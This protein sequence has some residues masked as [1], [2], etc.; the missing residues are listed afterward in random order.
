MSRGMA[1]YE[2][3]QEMHPTAPTPAVMESE[4]K[5]CEIEAAEGILEACIDEVFVRPDVN[6]TTFV[7][8]I[9]ST[10]TDTDAEDEWEKE[11]SSWRCLPQHWQEILNSRLAKHHSAIQDAKAFY[12]HR[13]EEFGAEDV[14]TKNAQKKMTDLQSGKNSC[15]IVLIMKGTGKEGGQDLYKRCVQNLKGE[16]KVS[17]SSKVL[18]HKVC[19]ETLKL[20]TL[21]D[22]PVERSLRIVSVTGKSKE[23]QE[24]RLHLNLLSLQSSNVLGGT[25]LPSSGKAG[26]KEVEVGA[27]GGDKEGETGEEAGMENVAVLE[28]QFEAAE[29]GLI[30]AMQCEDVHEDPSKMEDAPEA[31][32]SRIRNLILTGIDRITKLYIPCVN[33]QMVPNQ[34]YPCKIGNGDKVHSSFMHREIPMYIR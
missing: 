29:D 32:V 7:W 6:R 21:E 14:K 31:A 8:Q 19:M 4:M 34:A 12:E 9:E 1:S 30:A 11:D 23:I 10:V 2:E 13:L 18:A 22:P 17:V 15:S 24:V 28:D 27:Q 25:D 26:D 16:L 20:V 33:N 3:M 5:A